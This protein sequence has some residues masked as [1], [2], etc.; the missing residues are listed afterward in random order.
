MIGPGVTGLTVGDA[1]LGTLRGA[2]GQGN[3]RGSLAD[4]LVVSADDVT[5]KPAN[6]SFETAGVLG[7]AAQT[8]SGAFRVLNL[9]SDDVL[10]IAN[11][12][13]GIGSLATQLAVHRGARVIGIASQRNAA[14]LRSLGAIPVE[15]GDDVEQRIREA[16][17]A[18][19]TK[20]LDGH[21]GEYTKVGFALGLSG[22]AIGSLAPNPLAI[23]RGAWFT[24]SRHAEPG[25]LEEITKLV[26]DGIITIAI[27]RAYPFDIDSIRQHM[28]N[29][30]RDMSE[31]NSSSRWHDSVMA[32]RQRYQAARSAAA[33]HA[34]A[35]TTCA[36]G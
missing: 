31:G 18:P 29:S 22:K 7:V 35:S 15:Y 19:L 14:Y 33:H 9:T 1:A 10:A 11:A 27:E 20:L 25:D 24:G 8:V 12:S 32:Y 23:M 4:T 3:K 2:P 36:D 30:P 16:A 21:L 17:P 28:S 13:G 5:P 34:P 26:A 6:V